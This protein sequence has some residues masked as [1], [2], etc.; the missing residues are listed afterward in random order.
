MGK[1]KYVVYTWA[2]RISAVLALHLILIRAEVKYSADTR[3]QMHVHLDY[4]K[5]EFLETLH[6]FVNFCGGRA[7]F[8]RRN[9][10][11]P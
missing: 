5:P 10:L 3:E 1:Y 9:T 7:F 8:N 4:G 6:K 2:A 11:K